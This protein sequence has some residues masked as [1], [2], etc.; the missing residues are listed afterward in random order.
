MKKVFKQF[1]DTLHEIQKLKEVKESQLV[2]PISEGKWSIREI[3]GH[4]YYWDKYILEN[5]VPAMFNGANLPQFP[6]HDQHNKEAISYLIDYSVDEI[7]D[8]FTETRKELIES[9]LIVVEDVRFTIG[10]GNRQFSVESFIKMFV[11][12]DI[13]H[14]KQIK[15]K[16]SH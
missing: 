8:A 1:E 6:D 16:L 13:H 2:D 9:T 5:M 12:H 14:L 11:E 7:I 4:L 15:E 10:S 3:I